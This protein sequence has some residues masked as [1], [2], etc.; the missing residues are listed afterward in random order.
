MI[1]LEK[2]LT[3]PMHFIDTNILTASQSKMAILKLLWAQ[4]LTPHYC[5]ICNPNMVND[6]LSA[7]LASR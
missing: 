4:Q 2:P 6:I 3:S 1:Y 7:H 5:D